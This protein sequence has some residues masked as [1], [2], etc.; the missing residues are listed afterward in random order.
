MA[1]FLLDVPEPLLLRP[2]LVV[3][4]IGGGGGGGGGGLVRIMLPGV[5]SFSFSIFFSA[6]V[7]MLLFSGNKILVF[8]GL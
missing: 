7:E 1:D 8:S 3:I 2:L 5:P 4:L 6:R